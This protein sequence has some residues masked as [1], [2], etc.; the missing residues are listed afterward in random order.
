MNAAPEPRRMPFIELLINST[1]ISCALQPDFIF[2]SGIQL[3]PLFVLDTLGQ[4]PAALGLF[5][6]A[7]SGGALS[8]L[9][10]V[11]NA[12]SALLWE[13]FLKQHIGHRIHGKRLVILHKLLG[14]S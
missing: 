4:L 14:I 2:L 8:T 11:I 1:V 6:A 9:S 13:D 10:S 5:M 12:A 7:L 3:L